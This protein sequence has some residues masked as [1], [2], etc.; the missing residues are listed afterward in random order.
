MQTRRDDRK[1]GP[2]PANG[3]G[4]DP[5]LRG[6][7]LRDCKHAFF[8]CDGRGD[9]E[10]D[11]PHRVPTFERLGHLKNA[12]DKVE[13]FQPGTDMQLKFPPRPR[14]DPDIG[15]TWP[16]L[17]RNWLLDVSGVHA[18]A[19][20]GCD[21]NET[22]RCTLSEAAPKHSMHHTRT[23]S[24]SES[25]ES[26]S[27]LSCAVA[28]AANCAETLNQSM[29]NVYKV[30][31]RRATV[32]S[33]P[34]VSAVA[35]LNARMQE[36]C[37]STCVAATVVPNLASI[38]V[39]G[40]CVTT[41]EGTH[42][43]AAIPTVSGLPMLLQNQKSTSMRNYFNPFVTRATTESLKD[44]WHHRDLKAHSLCPRGLRAGR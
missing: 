35:Y 24:A 25:I 27:M 43:A 12:A 14:K 32:F 13:W 23:T 28:D 37:R 30:G 33:E 9:I 20:I 29:Q 2:P 4:S 5:E 38:C 36:V 34:E 26:I 17:A 42:H 41:R 21:D 22:D 11:K 15:R 44:C 39:D 19:T 18:G 16:E 10:W 3:G 40:G 31:S 7:V 1:R 6:R 8:S